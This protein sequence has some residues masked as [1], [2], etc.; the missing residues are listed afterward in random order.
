MILNGLEYD[1]GTRVY[2]YPGKFYLSNCCIETLSTTN[3]FDLNTTFV[4]TEV[5][6]GSYAWSDSTLGFTKDGSNATL[7]TSPESGTARTLT[8]TNLWEVDV[9]EVT[10]A[11]SIDVVAGQE[12]NLS[13]SLT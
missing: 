11:A 5:T 4:I 12:F 1:Q 2:V 3:L 8:L 10:T 6:D 13:V 9:F 7:T